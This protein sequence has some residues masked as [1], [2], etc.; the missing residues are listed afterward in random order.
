MSS[1]YYWERK[2]T[3]TPTQVVLLHEQE[4]PRMTQNA[5]DAPHQ[6]KSMVRCTLGKEPPM[7]VPDST[8]AY[9]L[10]SCSAMRRMKLVNQPW[11]IERSVLRAVP[12]TRINGPVV[13]T[14]PV[15]SGMPFLRIMHAKSNVDVWDEKTAHA[16]YQLSYCSQARCDK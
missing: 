2:K 12:R 8:W 1:Y 6:R 7:L 4:W 13:P 10:G 11:L 5:L 16:S 15:E 14:L 9:G 3:E